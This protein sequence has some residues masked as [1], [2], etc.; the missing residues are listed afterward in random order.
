MSKK[1]KQ[2]YAKLIANPGAGQVLKQASLITEVAD[3]LIQRGLKVDVALARPTKN[4][5]KAAKK[6]VKQGYDIVIAMGGDG[7][8]GGAIRGMVNSKARLGVIAAGTEN[9]FALSL[10]IPEDVHRACDVI[11][12]G[13]TR[14]IDLGRLRT[15]KTDHFDFFM[16][17][18]VG[19]VSTVYPMIKGVPAGEYDKIADA[20]KTLFKFDAAPKVFLTLDDQPEFEVETMLVT[21]TNVPLIGL[22]NLVAPDSSLEDGL[23]DVSLYPGFSKADIIAYFAR[24]LNEN[25][26]GYDRVQRYRAR[27]IKI[28]TSP[29]LDIAAEGLM[30]GKGTA[31][32]KALPGALRIL[33]PEPGTGAEKPIDATQSSPT[34]VQ[35]TVSANS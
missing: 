8:I 28:R 11:L 17:T 14:T 27:K 25:E 7:T 34:A 31:W 9:D 10:G 19:I 3:Y 30:M 32:I 6:A 12:A 33:A 18:T 20:I 13:N 15:K 24:T 2:L 26:P 5:A 21:I 1:N 23:L 16:V 35:Q 4:V 22:H 29:K